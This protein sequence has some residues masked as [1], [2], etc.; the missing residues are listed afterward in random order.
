MVFSH[1]VTPA[2]DHDHV[3]PGRLVPR[4]FCCPCPEDM[5]S[6]RY[7][8]SQ[9]YERWKEIIQYECFCRDHRFMP[10]N[11]PQLNPR[12]VLFFKHTTA[13]ENGLILPLSPISF[14][15]GT[16]PQDHPKSNGLSSCFIL[17]NHPHLAGQQYAVALGYLQSATG[18]LVTSVIGYHGRW[19]CTG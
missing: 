10:Y 13:E 11:Y 8:T 1:Q 15:V 18:G 14:P 16:G 2:Q 9:W 5:S 19:G 6:P 3:L 17:S 12:K 7:S 4:P